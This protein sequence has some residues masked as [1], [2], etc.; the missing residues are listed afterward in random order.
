MAHTAHVE[1]AAWDQVVRPPRILQ[2]ETHEIDLRLQ[3]YTAAEH[4]IGA[5]LQELE[6]HSVYQLLSTGVLTG[7]TAAALGSVTDAD[8][9]LWQLYTLLGSSLDVVRRLRGTDNRVSGNEQR[10]LTQRLTT[11]SVLI[12]S[13]DVPL[14]ERG[15]TGASIREEH[16]TIEALIERMSSLYEPVRD[17]I[18]H[19]ETALRGLL[20]RLNSAEATMKRLRSDAVGLGVDTVELDRIDETIARIRDLSLTDPLSIPTDARSA[21]DHAIHE[22]TATIARARS[23][24]DELA[25]DI[26]GATELLDECRD[27]LARATQSREEAEAKI[28]QPIGLRTPPSPEA[29]DGPQGLAARLEPIVASTQPW[30]IVRRLLDEW[31]RPASRLRDQLHRVAEANAI[32][33]EKRDEL[34][35][36][37]SAF[38]AKMAATGFSEDLVLR[39]IS[40]EAHNELFTSPTDLTRAEKLVTEFGARLAT[41]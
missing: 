9:N 22:A 34:R 38:R 20:P 23:S 5:N 7:K 18:T 6:Q 27:L 13:E 14:G 39:D 16:I 32:P 3:R 21:F 10:E 1:A 40:A 4:R 11:A 29:I 24:H 35:G 36:R 25:T 15:L 41:S 30:Q 28:A 26:A 37:L 19:A 2:V 12:T 8:P 33:L 17:V 31:S